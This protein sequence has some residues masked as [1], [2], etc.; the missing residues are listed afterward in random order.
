VPQAASPNGDSLSDFAQDCCRLVTSFAPGA[1]GAESARAADMPVPGGAPNSY[2][3]TSYYPVSP[4]VNWGGVYIGLNGG[5]GFGQSNWS[6]SLGSTGDFAVNGGIFGG[7]LGINYAGFGDW[8]LL[9]FEGD[10]D[11]S[12]ATGSAGCSVLGAN[13][14][15][16]ATCQTRIDW[17]STFRFRAGYTWSHFLFYAT[18][19]G[20]VGDFRISSEPT[21]ANHN[22]TSPLGWTAGVGVEYLFNDAVSVKLEYLYVDLLSVG[23]PTA[24][25][26]GG[27]VT[28]PGFLCSADNGTGSG[29]V[30]FTENLI[31]LG[32]N[33][34]F[35]W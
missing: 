12:G 4:P 25:T 1:G 22:P 2:Y 17:L 27:T 20:A 3:P 5:Y 29:S 26:F 24:S 14:G 34:K 23:C 8:V 18:A 35:S 33:Y 16:G 21:G 7:T 15:A 9:G 6:N 19:G 13:L 28:S 11:W 30:S 10:F 31:R 32:V